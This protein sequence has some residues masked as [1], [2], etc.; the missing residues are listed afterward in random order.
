[1]GNIAII[2][3]LKR[4]E[5]ALQ[6]EISIGIKTLSTPVPIPK[7]KGQMDFGI[8]CD[9]TQLEKNVKAICF[10]LYNVA[11][12]IH[13]RRELSKQYNLK[14]R[15]IDEN[16]DNL[17]KQIPILVDPNTEAFYFKIPWKIKQKKQ[18]YVRDAFYE[19]LSLPENVKKIIEKMEP[20][21][22]N[23]SWSTIWNE[24]MMVSIIDSFISYQS[25]YN[26]DIVIP[27][28]PLVTGSN[29]TMQLMRS[30]N[31]KARRPISEIYGVISS[32]YIP[33]HYKIF[34][35][36]DD[37]GE[38]IREDI[39]NYIK[40]NIAFY[41]FLVIKL[42]W[43]SNISNSKPARKEYGKFLSKI[44]KIKKEMKDSFAVILLDAGAEG[45]YTL[46]NSVD[47]FVEPVGKRA[48]VIRGSKKEDDEE[49]EIIT[50]GNYLHPTEGWIPFNRLL[51][52]VKENK[53]LLPCSCQ[54]CDKYHGI[55]SKD[56]SKLEWNIARRSHAINLRRRQVDTIAGSINKG[57]YDDIILR[58]D[59]DEDRNFIDLLPRNSNLN[60]IY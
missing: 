22:Y 43:Y 23:Q 3:P 20:S 17:I 11:E 45:R 40:E 39:I 4:V 36:F 37:R 56:I 15:S 38:K 28:V 52:I 9:N 59:V 57:K 18:L 41:K 58:I 49:I 44:D 1:M 2:N 50:H 16:Y 30:I 19:L 26:A 10:D 21:N 33:L 6:T 32:M 31:S 34:T 14:M 27:P 55:L 29:I 35:R 60:N 54:A 42:V 47:C 51:E 53:G 25:L 7:I 46:A 48:G 24:E 8:V 5:G 12:I 13:K